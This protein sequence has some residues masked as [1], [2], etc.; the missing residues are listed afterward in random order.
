MKLFE[1]HD[2]IYSENERGSLRNLAATSCGLGLLWAWFMYAGNPGTKILGVEADVQWYFSTFSILSTAVVFIFYPWLVSKGY[3][4]IHGIV[5]TVLFATLCTALAVVGNLNNALS[6]SL[7]AVCGI[8]A[9]FTYALPLARWVQNSIGSGYARLF[10]PVGIGSI[11]NSVFYSILVFQ[12]GF[13]TPWLALSMPIGAMLLFTWVS[14]NPLKAE[15]LQNKQAARKSKLLYYCSLLLSGGFAKSLLMTNWV[16]ESSLDWVWAMAPFGILAC[17]MIIL[18]KEKVSTDVLYSALIGITCIVVILTL[19]LPT[20]NV[21]LASTIFASAWYLTVFSFA[22][23]VW[24][25]ST[26]AHNSL[27]ASCIALVLI[28]SSS[29][30]SS[31]ISSTLPGNSINLL[32]ISVVLLAI[33]LVFIVQANSSH[34]AEIKETNQ[35]IHSINNRL[36]EL[37]KTYGI[38]E[39]EYDVLTLLAKGNSVKSISKKLFVSENTVKSHRLHIYH[40]LGVSSRQSLIDMLD[41]SD[42]KK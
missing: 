41:D 5:A 33:S 34:F 14:K 19:I 4:S 39:R 38:T 40:K 26:Y 30:I 21:F 25:G 3:K 20:H 18:F 7:L 6:S 16:P 17:C 37:T 10:L 13:L 22:A 15:P 27:K 23:S 9:G 28:F 31:F 29:A 32:V 11:L 1:I 36:D 2:R 35:D 24:L 12:P 8:L 42:L